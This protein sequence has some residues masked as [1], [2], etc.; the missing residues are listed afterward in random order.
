[1][2]K[3]EECHERPPL[4]NSA[5]S[6]AT[7]RVEQ[8]AAKATARSDFQFAKLRHEVTSVF[9][10]LPPNRLYAYS[11]WLRLLVAQ[12]LQDIACATRSLSGSR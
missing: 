6:S 3:A 5:A 1:M 8:I 2:T 10:V 9:L 4:P 12:A 11:R 7:I